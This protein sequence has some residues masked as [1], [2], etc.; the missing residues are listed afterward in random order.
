MDAFVVEDLEASIAYWQETSGVERWCIAADL[1]KF[2]RD[3]E[4][5]GE[6]EDFQLIPS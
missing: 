2:Q 5:W 6:P 1:A 3:K 4:Y